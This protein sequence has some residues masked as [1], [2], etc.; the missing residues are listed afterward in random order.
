MCKQ[1]QKVYFRD[2][3]HA[4]MITIQD[5]YSLYKKAI[6]LHMKEK[7]EMTSQEQYALEKRLTAFIKSEYEK[8]L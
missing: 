3:K 2:N 1:V 8:Q 5:S 7:T 4:E 6:L